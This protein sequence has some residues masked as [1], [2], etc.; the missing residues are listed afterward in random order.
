MH[1]QKRIHRLEQR[2]AEHMHQVNSHPTHYRAAKFKTKMHD[3]FGKEEKM[4]IPT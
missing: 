2:Q 1:H 4:E 3:V